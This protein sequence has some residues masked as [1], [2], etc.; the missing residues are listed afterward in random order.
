MATVRKQHSQTI[1]SHIL[2]H[3]REQSKSGETLLTEPFPR[4][5]R[6]GSEGS[7]GVNGRG[8]PLRHP[9]PGGIPDVLSVIYTE[10]IVGD[11]RGPIHSDNSGASDIANQVAVS[12]DKIRLADQIIQEVDSVAEV[13]YQSSRKMIELVQEFSC[14]TQKVN[15]P[16][17][18][19]KV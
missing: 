6:R 10:S 4:R 11:K 9:C 12:A 2:R 14:L 18:Q 3:F 13:N 8:P 1:P 17:N 5:I 7:S 16:V 15:D 19:F